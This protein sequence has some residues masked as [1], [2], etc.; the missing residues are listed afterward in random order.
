MERQNCSVSLK[1]HTTKLESDI[2]IFKP[3]LLVPKEAARPKIK[4]LAFLGSR[5]SNEEGEQRERTVKQQRET[6]H[7]PGQYC[8]CP[9]PLLEQL[10]DADNYVID[11][12][13]PRSLQHRKPNSIKTG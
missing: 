13:E 5:K 7:Q 2:P 9:M 1:L 10:Q 3:S 6:T 12:T 11:V 8:T 4:L